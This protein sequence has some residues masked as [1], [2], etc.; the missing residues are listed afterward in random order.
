MKKLCIAVL[1]GLAA[2]S[3]PLAAQDKP[4]NAMSLNGVTGIYVVPTA[5]IGFSEG[6]GLNAGYHTNIFKPLGGDTEMN[7][8]V[9]A[10]FS[11]LQMFEVAAAFDFQPEEAQ[12]E[13]PN[14]FLTG[15]KVQLP[16]LA[17]PVALGGNL[18]YLNIGRDN[19]DHWAFQVYGAVTYEADIF[20]WPAA[21]TLVAGH[22][23]YENSES[24]I[25]FGMGFDLIVLPKYLRHFLHLLIDYANFSY[26]FDPWG[27]G[28]WYRGVLNAGL[29]ADLGQI[30]ALNKF[31]FAV[32][33]YVADAFDDKDTGRGEG[34]ALGMGVTFGMQF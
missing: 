23:F 20:T 10:N 9:K 19:T 5:H 32:D 1:I 30:P 13:N 15:I 28:A 17:I 22:T 33:I 25:D 21:T 26:S 12:G 14:D 18:Q 16:F 7:H 8:L 31:T 24:N 3:L 4:L 29:R 11:F 34:R 27:A 2:F 6:L